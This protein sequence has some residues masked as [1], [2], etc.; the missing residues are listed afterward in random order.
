MAN[1]DINLAL[2]LSADSRLLGVGLKQGERG[3]TDFSRKSQQ[4]LRKLGRVTD[5]VRGHFSDMA[6]SFAKAAGGLYIA[7]KIKPGVAVAGDLQEAMLGVRTELMGSVDGA[8]AMDK[9]LHAMKSTAFEIQKSTPFDQAQIVNLEKELLKGGAKI[10]QIVGKQGA[11]AAAAALAAYEGIGAVMAGESLISIATPFNLTGDQFMMLANQAAAAGSASTASFDTIAEGAKYAAGSMAGLGRDSKEMFALLATLDQGGLK[12]SMGG[13]SLSAFFRQAVKVN[14]FKDANGDLKST[15]DI[16]DTLR[17]R[18]DGMGTAKRAGFLQKVFGDEGGR[19]AQI[20]LRQGAGSYED[21]TAQMAK[22]VG[23]QDKLAERL[24]GYN[25]QLESLRGTAKSTFATMFEPALDPLTKLISKT[26]E[27]AGAL[28]EAALENKKV[29]QIGT[30]VAAGVAGAGLL[31]GGYHLLKG[32]GSGGKMLGALKGG[33]EL[34]GGVA[35]GKAL[36]E[37]AGVPSVYVVNMPKEFGGTV[38][39]VGKVADTAGDLLKPKTFSKLKTTMALLGGAP[40]SALPS[41]GAGAMATAGAAVAGAGAAGYGVGTLINDYLIDGT[42][43]GDAIGSAIAHALS[44]FSEDARAAIAANQ[45]AEAMKGE[46]T[47]R[48]EGDQRAKVTKLES[49][50]GPDLSVYTGLTGAGR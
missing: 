3:V 39:T 16:L 47:I 31:Y 50:G 42:A 18:M 35:M 17:K 26:N 12:G 41:F 6:G 28:G 14:A 22:A 24:K 44:P 36:E 49:S 7:N 43:V 4:E 23:L 30:G 37:A 19:A 11:A 21:M 10:E 34:A 40:L 38:G 29:G 20:L 45:R 13:T 15:V 5:E 25:A 32:L 27:W 8:L 9:A 1:R 2:R 46:I 48:L 33:T